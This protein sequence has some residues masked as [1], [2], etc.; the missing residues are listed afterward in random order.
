[1]VREGGQSS[2]LLVDRRIL[3]DIRVSNSVVSF[4]ELVEARCVLRLLS[5]SLSLS[6]S[7]D[8]LSFFS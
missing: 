7:L 5:R 3:E 6:L 4:H 1:M 2:F 8:L